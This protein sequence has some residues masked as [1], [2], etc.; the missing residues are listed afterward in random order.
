MKHDVVRL[1]QLDSGLGFYR[2]VYHG[3][4]TAYVG[5]IAQEVERVR[6]EAVSRDRE[7]YLRVRYDL[8]GLKFETYQQWLASGAQVPVARVPAAAGERRH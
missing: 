7:G 8:L 6:P 1:G 3:D 4:R 2:F 5:V